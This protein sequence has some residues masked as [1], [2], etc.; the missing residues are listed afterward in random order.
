MSNQKKHIYGTLT[1]K[2]LDA[3]RAH[4]GAS[5]IVR[6]LPPCTGDTYGKRRS[7]YIEV[8]RL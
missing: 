3:I 8:Q 4:P 7:F 2:I 6:M 5:E 1:Q